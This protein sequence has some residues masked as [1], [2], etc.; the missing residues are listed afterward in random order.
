[1]YGEIGSAVCSEVRVTFYIFFGA[2][3]RRIKCLNHVH[4]TKY[5]EVMHAFCAANS[6]E[7]DYSTV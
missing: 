4:S 2:P 7:I 3:P 1:M 6:D 5:V